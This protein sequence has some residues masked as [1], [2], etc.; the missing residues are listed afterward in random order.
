[1]SVDKY[2]EKVRGNWS[3]EN[4]L[5]WH[6]DVTFNENACRARSGYTLENFNIL[7]K[8]ALLKLKEEEDKLSLKT[9]P[10]KNKRES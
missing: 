3:I 8:F 5:H 1:M 9:H 2:N 10:N 4:H 7:R 6:L